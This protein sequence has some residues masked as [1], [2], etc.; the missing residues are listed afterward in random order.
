MVQDALTSKVLY[1]DY[2][3][4][5]SSENIA[6]IISVVRDLLVKHRTLIIAVISDHQHSIRL[7]VKK[8]LPE[9]GHQFCH[10]HV[11]RNALLP[12][13][14]MD[15][16]LKK[17][18]RIRIRGIAEIE[19]SVSAKKDAH[20]TVIRDAC[21][22]LRAL[23]IY[24]GT[25]P[26]EFSGMVVYEN[27]SSLD[28]TLK[29]MIS[30]RHD[31][32]LVRLERIASRWEEFKPRYRDLSS[33]ASYAIR[34]RGILSSVSP[35]PKVKQ[36]L[37]RFIEEIRVKESRGGVYSSLGAMIDTIEN[38]WDGLFFCFDDDRIPRTDNGLEITIRHVKTGYRRMSGMRSWDSFVA[39][40][41]RS[42]FMIPPDVS[43]DALITMTRR[44]DRGEYSKRWKEFN[45]RR[46]TLSLMRTAR[47]DYASSLKYLEDSWN[48]R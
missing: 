39:Q 33:L 28:V 22:L 20:I 31:M 18:I 8:A 4:N 27:L 15:R 19:R 37:Q 32:D 5:S 35:S 10:F 47:T 1:A 21:S 23:L 44:V 9:T 13:A 17:D 45:S 2:L 7:G 26:L 30:S 11:L 38:H 48:S 6:S 3:D 12:I 14:D 43:R 25:S 46:R 41:G 42:S 34:L 36:S 40:Y 16:K 24:P 29:R